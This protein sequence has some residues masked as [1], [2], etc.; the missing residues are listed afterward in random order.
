VKPTYLSE[1][2]AT[3]L[4]YNFERNM[5]TFKVVNSIKNPTRSSSFHTFEGWGMVWQFGLDSGSIG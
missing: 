3:T 5:A 4:H 2:N 1:W